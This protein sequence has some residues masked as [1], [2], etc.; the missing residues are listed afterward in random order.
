MKTRLKLS[1]V[2]KIKY[3]LYPYF[4][5]T[6]WYQ[7][8]LGVKTNVLDPNY[9]TMGLANTVKR[10]NLNLDALHTYGP[11]INIT[12]LPEYGMGLHEL[13]RDDDQEAIVRFVL[14][15]LQNA[16][17]SDIGVE[18]SFWRSFIPRNEGYFVTG[19]GQ[20]LLLS[21]L[22]RF[23]LN[24][25]WSELDRVIERIANSY[26]IPF[27]SKNGFVKWLDPDNAIIEEYPI[28]RTKS[29]VLNGWCYGIF[30]L[31][32]YLNY[33]KEIPNNG[34]HLDEKRR[35][36]D[37]TLDTLRRVL[38]KYDTGFWSLYNLPEAGEKIA[39]VASWHYHAAHI[40]LLE[41]LWHMTGDDI[42][43]VYAT[44][45]RYYSSSIFVRLRALFVKIVFS[46]ALK[47]GYFY[48]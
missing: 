38:P 3:K 1:F 17:D 8:N 19:M 44:R 31:F 40:A 45:F 42:Y 28:D 16:V 24:R 43:K 23:N 39:N 41:A 20:G 2:G 48:R 25:A 22:C 11:T 10:S 47:Y 27:E 33:R 14:T 29:Q 35:L 9:W 26:L 32:D 37:T 12:G 36:L 30:G 4:S 15:H 6:S 13:G 21:F 7:A 34:S 5:A 18:Y 46:N